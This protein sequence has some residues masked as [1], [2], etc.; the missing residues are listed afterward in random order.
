MLDNTCLLFIEQPLVRHQARREQSPGRPRRRSSVDPSRR[1]ARSTIRTRATRTASSA[2]CTS[3]SW[4]GWASRFD[5]FGDADAPSPGSE[6]NPAPRVNVRRLHPRDRGHLARNPEGGIV[7]VQRADQEIIG[8]PQAFQSVVWTVR[9]VLIGEVGRLLAADDSGHVGRVIHIADVCGEGD[10]LMPPCDTL[11][12]PLRA[13]AEPTGCRAVGC[14]ASPRFHRRPGAAALRHQLRPQ[15]TSPWRAL[16]DTRAPPACY[17]AVRHPGWRHGASRV[18]LV[19]Y[20]STPITR[21]MM[22]HPSSNM[23]PPGYST[24]CRRA[25]E[26]E[27][28][29]HDRVDFEHVPQPTL[30]QKGRGARPRAGLYRY[31]YPIWT[32]RFSFA[33]MSRII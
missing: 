10:L 9:S 33:A 30:L 22:W 15:W 17:R 25:A 24:S 12:G 23:M 8:R 28:L 1:A 19:G 21:S 14:G 13:P 18:D 3:P 6:S 27:N 16:A 11:L 29:A 7:A 2:A 20:R 32:S 26:V 5:R 31:M 4:T